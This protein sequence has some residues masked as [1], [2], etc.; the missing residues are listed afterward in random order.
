MSD[1][2]LSLLMAVILSSGSAQAAESSGKPA[3]PYMTLQPIGL[4]AIVHGR[5]VNYI[6]VDFRLV[7]GKGVDPSHLQDR[8]P[9]LRDALVRA[10]TRTPFNLPDDGVRL[11]EGR[12]KAQ[13]MRAVISEIGPG[14]ISSVEI[15]SQTPQRRTG[16]PGGAT[17]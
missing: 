6:F 3:A 15:L 13:V 16:V 2:R 8:E 4:P 14:K 1:W 11:D 17:P 12:L 10:A 9:F 5:L 7:L